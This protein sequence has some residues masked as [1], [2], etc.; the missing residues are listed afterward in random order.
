[1]SAVLPSET[2]ISVDVE[3]AGPVPRL[4]SMLSI[5][6]C[7]VEEPT[8]TFYIELKPEVPDF[9][10]AAMSISGLSFAELEEGGTD[11][12]EGMREFESWLS[13]EVPGDS[14]PVF[15][16]FNAPFDWMFVDD[17]FHRLLGRNP[18]G[19]TALDIK[20]YALGVLGGS[21]TETSMRYLSPRFLGGRKLAHNALGDAQDQAE[22]FRA[23]RDVK[24]RSS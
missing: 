3:T 19:H 7:F 8:R 21:W 17:Y 10:E 20:S 16:G 11:P 12:A 23:I 14:L 22:L 18:F 15:V 6:A 13:T 5:G 24:D 9:L 1:M 4:Y 2:L